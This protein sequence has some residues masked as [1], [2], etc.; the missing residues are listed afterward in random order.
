[1]S[2]EYI[3]IYNHNCHL[4]QAEADRM[5]AEA[6]EEQL[7]NDRL[8]FLPVKSPEQTALSQ[9]IEVNMDGLATPEDSS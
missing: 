7:A 6:A 8:R 1:M 9:T 4:T 2:E 3:G 5:L